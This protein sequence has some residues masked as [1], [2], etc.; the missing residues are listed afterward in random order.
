MIQYCISCR[1]Y[2]SLMRVS[3]RQMPDDQFFKSALYQRH[4]GCVV[5]ASAVPVHKVI[6]IDRIIY[7]RESSRSHYN[8]LNIPVISIIQ[9]VVIRI[10]KL[11]DHELRRRVD[12]RLKALSRK[13][14]KRKW[15]RRNHRLHRGR[16]RRRQCHRRTS[17]LQHRRPL[18]GC[19]CHRLHPRRTPPQ[20][21]R[22]H[23]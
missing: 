14:G 17:G 4:I 23:A 3:F 18:D 9:A 19:G 6:D 13:A 20:T 11:P 12:L 16:S 22:C 8:S 5:P 15:R 21:R 2:C 10:M 7:K 1:L